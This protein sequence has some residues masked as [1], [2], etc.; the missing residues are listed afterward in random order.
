MY[1]T[2]IVLLLLGWTVFVIGN[3]TNPQTDQITWT[4]A[5]QAPGALPDG[6]TWDGTHLWV[7]A[8]TERRIYRVDTLGNIDTVISNPATI[9]T[10]L[11]WDG[12]YLWC[13]D[14]SPRRIF[15][16]NPA[17]GQIIRQFTPP[18]SVSNEGLAWDGTYLWNTNWYNN[19]IWKLDTLGT[20]I[21]SFPAPGAPNAASTGLTWDGTY[22]WNSDQL[23]D[24]VYQIDPANGSVVRREPAPDTVVQDL[25]FDGQKLWVVGYYSRNVF[26]SSAVV[27]IKEKPINLI[28]R[29]RLEI[30]PNPSRYSVTVS[31]QLTKPDWIKI[32]IYD[33]TGRLLKSLTN[34]VRN[35]GKY[36]VNWQG[37]SG[38]YFCRIST[39]VGSITKKFVIQ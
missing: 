35:P 26:K 37:T 36:S 15:K 21:T 10:G 17:N 11:A 38:L 2:K 25:A 19:Q 6:L 3:T 14:H 16:I 30:T 5:F 20:V 4:F 28:E 39:S 24:S 29:L 32:S 22:L 27:G 31:Y 34:E 8:E 7:T 1:L 12:M 33:A 9:P 13:G 18:G 23:R